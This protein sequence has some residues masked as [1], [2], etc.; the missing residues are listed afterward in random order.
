MTGS[1]PAGDPRLAA[2]AHAIEGRPDAA[3]LFYELAESHWRQGD[4]DG[5]AHFFRRAFLL[6]PIS[7]I[8]QPAGIAGY[9]RASAPALRAR[10][11][12]LVAGGA[13]FTPAIAALAVTAAQLGRGDEA[14]RLMDH[15]T[16]LRTGRIAPPDGVA[17]EAFNAAVAGEIRTNLRYYGEPGGRAIRHA[18]RFNGLLRENSPHLRRLVGILRKTVADYIAALPRDAGHAFLSQIP[19]DFEVG[20][21]AVASEGRSHHESHLHP[22]AWATGV[23]YVV[24]PQIARDAARR[25]GWLTIGPPPELETVAEDVWGRRHIAPAAGSFVLMPGYFWH[26]T[27][28]MGVDQERICVA[29]EVRRPELA[30]NSADGH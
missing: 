22:R 27:E 21:W 16:L 24:E 5:Y 9:D 14:Q 6:E 25:R 30:L 19:D 28:P 18:W 10:A 11:H 1:Q 29:F 23:Y 7:H 2:L 12:A 20:G 3:A 4:A 17:L 8:G 15:A 26:A 13:A